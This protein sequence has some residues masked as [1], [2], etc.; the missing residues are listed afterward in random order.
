RDA[1][2]KLST[3]EVRVNIIRAAVGNIGESDILLASAS[4]AIVLGFNVRADAAARRAAQDEGIEIRT[5]R[6]IYELLEAVEAAMRGLL[7]PI[8]R[9]VV[10]GKAEVRATFRLPSGQ[11]VAGCYVQDGRLVRGADVR[12]T[13]NGEVIHEGSVDSLRHIRENVREMAAG[14]ECGVLVDGFNDF[15]EGDVLQAYQTEQVARALR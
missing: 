4:N 2:V 10:L 6:I 8:Y 5:Y 15:Q 12:V 3:D 1:L 13:R 11:V 9:E 14:Y 7:Q